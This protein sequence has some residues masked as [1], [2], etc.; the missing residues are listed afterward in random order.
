MSKRFRVTVEYDF[1][2]EDEA[3]ARSTNFWCNELDDTI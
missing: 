1:Y 2:A 3:E